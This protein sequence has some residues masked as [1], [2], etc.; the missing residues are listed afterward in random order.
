MLARVQSSLLQ[1]IDALSC[2]VEVDHTDLGDGDEAKSFAAI[3]GLPDAAVK[4]SLERVRSA[5]TNSGYFFPSGRTI[6]NLAPADVRK[7]G[8]VYDLPIAI[9]ALLVQG[10]AAPVKPA[11]APQ[12]SATQTVDSAGIDHRRYLFAGELA[13][14]GRLRPIKGAIALA[15][16]AREKG[17]EGVVIPYDNAAEAAVVEGIA[18]LGA[19]SLAEVVGLLTGHLEPRPFPSPDVANLLRQAS[20]PID[21]AEIKGQESVKRAIVVAAAGGHNLVM[22]GPAGTGKTMMAKALPGVLP[23][24]TPD[25]AIQ[26]TRIYSAAGQL[27]PGQGLVTTRPVRTPHHTASGAAIVGGGMI[28]RPGEISLAHH[29]VLFLDELPEFPRD[30]LETLRQPMEDHVVTIARSHSAVRFPANFMLVAAMNPTP[31]GDIAPGEV[32]RM[33]MERYLSKLSGPL[34]DRIDIHIEAPAVPFRELSRRSEQATGTSTAQMREQVAKARERQRRR[35]GDVPNARL[36]GKKLDEM[37]GLDENAL[38]MLGQ[39]MNEMGL[40]AR[41]FDK[42][43]RIARTIADLADSEGVTAEHVGEAVQYRLL[44]R[45][46]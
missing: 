32:G 40:S 16:L 3:V 19:R 35:Q 15:A 12:K 33:E 41:A 2:E 5:L 17:F 14:D 22:L 45:K 37:A 25:E 18:V 36:S 28:P 20:A 31:R 34:L 4:E 29:G 23:A 26:V 6:V 10:I 21:F 11:K 46:V 7:E 38:T 24:L 43:R 13:L 30:V 39:A 44:D 9:G 27:A 8:P 1:G 42:L